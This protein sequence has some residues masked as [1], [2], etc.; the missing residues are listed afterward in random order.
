M[1]LNEPAGEFAEI[2]RKIDLENQNT[3]SQ[4]VFVRA[5]GGIFVLLLLAIKIYISFKM[6]S[7]Y[8]FSD[9]QSY[10]GM[11]NKIVSLHTDKIYNSH[12]PGYS[13]ILAPAYALAST[14]LKAYHIVLII[15]C[16]I[17]TCSY[18]LAYYLCGHVFHMKRMYAMSAGIITSLASSFYAYNYVVM[19]ETVQTV[20]YFAFYV[21]FC[22]AICHKKKNG[23]KRWIILGVITGYLPMVKT[24]ANIFF[25]L[26]LLF[27]VIYQ[28]TD[29]EILSKKGLLLS[30]KISLIVFIIFR[31]I[32][33]RN[34]GMYEGQASD[35][36]SSLWT[37]FHDWEHFYSFLHIF[38]AEIAQFA[39]GTGMIP[40]FF[41][42]SFAACSF[43]KIVAHKEKLLISMFTLLVLAGN[44]MITTIHA[45]YVYASQK[46]ATVYTRYLDFFQPIVIVSGLILMFRYIRLPAKVKEANQHVKIEI[47]LALLIFIIYP[48][49]HKIDVNTYSL[50]LYQN[51][52]FLNFAFIFCVMF[53]LLIFLLIKHKVLPVVWLVLAGL[54]LVMDIHAVKI[55]L[56]N[57]K[58]MA[59]VYPAVFYLA[60]HPLYGENIMIDK[61]LKWKAD[62]EKDAQYVDL[63]YGVMFWNLKDNN[64]CVKKISKDYDSY[65]YSNKLLTRKVL[66][67][68]GSILL[69]DKENCNN[70]HAD[71]DTIVRTTNYVDFANM[72]YLRVL[73]NKMVTNLF[74]NDIEKFT[75]TYNYAVNVEVLPQDTDIVCYANQIPLKRVPEE[76][77]SNRVIFEYDKEEPIS[78]ES[79]TVEYKG[80]YKD[81][82]QDG[83][84][85]LGSVDISYQ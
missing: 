64:V 72:E 21:I 54:Y 71:I 23:K 84:L 35:N 1:K 2:E 55:Q 20:F 43:Q 8:I 34:V 3:R 27:A 45:Y 41:I 67:T 37:V 76:N 68:N 57:G 74:V 19:S 75:I 7:S 42:I 40:L 11:I 69:Y 73:N 9:E 31:F 38:L 77:V 51:I 30:L 13:L 32:I 70:Y 60:D 62:G 29:G 83:I 81:L 22:D 18:P 48:G 61:D 4:I 14:S 66:S 25:I 10:F 26:F 28:F 47:V 52:T 53:F 49:I 15:N 82:I 44:I 78:I 5:G 85:Y 6:K 59:E 16:L 63:R 56:Y 36:L 24:Q 46:N 65:I 50:K 33:F 17:G 39:V 58:Q 12:M 79:L 80:K